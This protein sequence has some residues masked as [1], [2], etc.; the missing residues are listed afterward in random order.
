MKVTDIISQSESE[1]C[2]PG[3][4]SGGGIGH[5]GVGVRGGVGEG[6]DG[7]ALPPAGIRGSSVVSSP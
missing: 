1:C 3:Y 2:T 6:R 5:E 4:L 7:T